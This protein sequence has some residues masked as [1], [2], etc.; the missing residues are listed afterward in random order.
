[1][2]ESFSGGAAARGEGVGVV[3]DHNLLTLARSDQ[4]SIGSCHCFPQGVVFLWGDYGGDVDIRGGN[5]VLS[6]L[7]SPRHVLSVT[8][9]TQHVL[10]PTWMTT[11]W[12]SAVGD[13]LQPMH[14]VVH[15]EA[16]NDDILV[17]F[18]GVHQVWFDLFKYRVPHQS[19]CFARGDCILPSF[20]SVSQCWGRRVVVGTVERKE[21]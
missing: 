9:F 8:V 6:S 7:N 3:N 10:T 11:R 4:S 21:G 13:A 1:M 15:G 18:V 20:P 16:R 2:V 12:T 14:E 19:V 5:T 17:R